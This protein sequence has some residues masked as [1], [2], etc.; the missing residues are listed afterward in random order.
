MKEL[1]ERIE[2]NPDIMMGKPDIRRTSIT[3]EII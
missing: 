3:V 1:L 2:I